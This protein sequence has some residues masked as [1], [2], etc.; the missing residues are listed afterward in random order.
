M[1]NRIFIFL[2]LTDIKDSVESKIKPIKFSHTYIEKNMCNMS[3]CACREVI[4][5]TSRRRLVY[6]HASDDEEE[7]I[8]SDFRLNVSEVIND[9]DSDEEH[10]CN[11]S[12]DESDFDA[13][14]D[15]V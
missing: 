11:D 7:K 2:L 8:I 5:M 14:E 3:Y 9:G 12:D 1:E 15:F 13:S 10:V 4:L 6:W